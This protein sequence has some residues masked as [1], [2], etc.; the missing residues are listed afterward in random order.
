M[1]CLFKK[2]KPKQINSRQAGNG[3]ALHGTLSINGTQINFIVVVLYECENDIEPN[4]YLHLV[5][6]Y[7]ENSP[8]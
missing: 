2:N 7:P 1:D 4:F 3:K 5:I 6:N 8:I